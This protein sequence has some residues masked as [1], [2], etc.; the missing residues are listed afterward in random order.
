METSQG[1][2]V[3]S[4]VISEEDHGSRRSR[5]AGQGSCDPGSAIHRLA[6]TACSVYI[7][8]G[9]PTQGWIAQ[10]VAG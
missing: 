8:V 10:G 3:K 5:A 4:D 1:S 7:C 9:V 6:S 2:P